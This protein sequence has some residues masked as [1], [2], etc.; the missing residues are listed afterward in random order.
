VWFSEKRKVQ[1]LIAAEKCGR[2]QMQS[3]RPKDKSFCAVSYV[4]ERSSA[5][6]RGRS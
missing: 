1:M 6:N 4:R 3:L 2:E 5:L